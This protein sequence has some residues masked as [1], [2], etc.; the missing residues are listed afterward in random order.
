MTHRNQR[1]V[2][3][4]VFLYP[5]QLLTFLSVF[6]LLLRFEIESAWIGNLQ[7][8]ASATKL[9]CHH[10][11]FEEMVP[12]IM[13]HRT[14]CASR[15]IELRCGVLQARNCRYPILG[16]E[17]FQSSRCCLSSVIICAFLTFYITWSLLN[18]LLRYF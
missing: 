14:S 11:R 12:K 17:T 1:Q 5:W 18:P 10:P 8:I 6:K 4:S 15:Q 3:T 2:T 13:S 7:L 9:S 16:Q